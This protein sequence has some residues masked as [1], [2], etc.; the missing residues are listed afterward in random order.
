MPCMPAVTHHIIITDSFAYSLLFCQPA[1]ASLIFFYVL[2]CLPA[3]MTVCGGGGGGGD[4][5]NNNNNNMNGAT[6]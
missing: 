5:R 1:A 3:D 2:K 4:I 6:D